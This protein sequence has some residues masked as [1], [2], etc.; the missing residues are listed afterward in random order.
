MRAGYTS[1]PVERTATHEVR[2]KGL[3]A[4]CTQE[5]ILI[6]P[7]SDL[8]ASLSKTEC[9]DWIPVIASATATAGQDCDA[10]KQVAEAAK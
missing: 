3:A 8:V 5:A 6:W 10:G 2:C 4:G 9:T 1:G 7:S